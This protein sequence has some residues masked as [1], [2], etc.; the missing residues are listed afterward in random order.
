M[1][2]A[3]LVSG[4]VD[5]SVALKLLKDQ[6]HD[7]TAFY[8]KIWLQD[9]LSFL[10]DC[11][12]QEDLN[13]VQQVCEQLDVP[14]EVIPL[15]TEYWDRIVNH[16][17]DQVRA[18]YT[19]NPDILCNRHI[20]FGAF[21][22]KIDSSYEK[23]ATGHYA[24]VTMTDNIAIL[25]MTPDAIKDQTYFLSQMSQTQLKRALFPL[26]D[27]DKAQVRTLAQE[28]DLPTKTRKDSQGICFLG[29]FKFSDFIKHHVGEQEG[30][31][32]E[33]ETGKVW[34][35]HKGFWFY[36]IGQRQ[37]L[38][39]AGGPWYVIDKD[40]AKNI[41]YISRNYYSDD[42]RRNEFIIHSCN[43]LSGV[44][45]DGDG[46]RVKLRHG[47]QMV[48]CT[49]LWLTDDRARVIL[50]KDDQ[51]I[52]SGQYAAFYKG[53]ACLGSGIMERSIND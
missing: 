35:M 37:G 44:R 45:P 28:F 42:K 51:G 2:I 43:W 12:W 39:L 46:I 27:L 15:Q 40:V 13:Y 1:K 30:E 14:L 16:T 38:G 10:G 26:G 50:E 11:P 8:L 36:T 22:D 23:I 29:K 18:G 34:G 52:A 4:G 17:I 21:F 3:V 48:P 49:I 5:S 19:P 47:P 33:V 31:L 41:V 6:G 53:N 24:K 32:I 20:K 25:S 7:V 9:E